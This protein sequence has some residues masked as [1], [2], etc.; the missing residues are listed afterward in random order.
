MR[1]HLEGRPLV[2]LCLLIS[3]DVRAEDWPTYRRDDRRSA[4][5]TQELDAPKLEPA[6]TRRVSLPP[7]PAWHGP[8]QRDAYHDKTDLTPMRDY[9]LVA[10]PIVVG[11]R[12]YYGSTS[13]DAV[14]CL[15]TRSGRELWRYTT[16]GPIRIA[17]T[18]SDGKLYFGSDDGHAYCI[19][20]D[21][22]ALLWS[23]SPTAGR[24]LVINNGRLI[25]F[26]P[27]RGGVI[28]DPS[29]G[30]GGTAYFSASLLPWK[31]SF[32]CAVSAASG[33]PLGDGRWVRRFAA[34]EQRT[35]EGAMAASGDHLLVPQGRSWLLDFDRRTGEQRKKVQLSG[36]GCFVM[37]GEDGTVAGGGASRGANVGVANVRTTAK[38]ISHGGAR[39][40]SIRGNVA[41]LI[42][43]EAL[44]AHDRVAKKRL[45]RAAASSCFAHIVTANA[46]F[47]GGRDVV[48]AH[49]TSDGKLLWSFAVQGDAHGLAA[50]DGALFVSTHDGV[51]QCFRPTA[52]VDFKPALGSKEPG[53]PAKEKK[54][55]EIE[56]I[57]L[58]SSPWVRFTTPDSAAVGWSTEQPSPTSLELRES[59]ETGPATRI[60]KQAPAT[61]HEVTLTGLRR[62]RKYSYSI[63]AL[64]DGEPRLAGPF[65]ID[66]FFN[67]RPPAV[68]GASDGTRPSTPPGSSGL[69]AELVTDVL[70]I[71]RGI[72]LLH[73]GSRGRLALELVRAGDLQVICVD[74]DPD[75]VRATRNLLA[76]AGVY[77]VRAC[78]LHVET[79]DDMPLPDGLANLVVS[80]RLLTRGG[81]SGS[82]TEI[83]RVLR[84]GSPV[85]LG[86][87]RREP[88]GRSVEPPRR[89]L[90]S[91]GLVVEVASTRGGRWIVARRER[92][93]GA[94]SWTHQYG[95][96]ANQAYAGETLGG[97]R[98]RENL[99]VQWIGRP[100]PRY[101]ADRM[102]RKPAPLAT[103][104]R[105][106]LQ[107][108]DRLIALD[109]HNGVPLWS[110]EI[111]GLRR[112]NLP[113]DCANYCADDSSVYVALR[114]ECWRID[115]ATG[116][117][118]A[119]FPVV[120][121]PRAD[122]P[123]DWSFIASDGDLLVGSAT[124]RGSAY[125]GFQGKGAWYDKNGFEKVTSDSLFAVEKDSAGTRWSWDRGVIINSSV[126]L[127]EGAVF[128]LESRHPRVREHGSG[129][130]GLAELWQQ[131]FLVALDSSSG[132]PLWERELP[133]TPGHVMVSLAHGRGRVVLVASQSG[134]FRVSTFDAKSGEPRWSSSV[135][136][137][138]PD[139]GGH[140]SRP[141]IVDRRMYIA[142]AWFDL[143]TGE[144]E[145]RLVYA[146]CG[147]YS[148]SKNTI[149]C[150]SGH[151]GQM[152]MT[153]MDSF[154]G[155][156][157]GRLRPGCWLSTIPSNGMVLV[158]EGGG[159]CWCSIWMETSLAFAPQT[160]PMPT[161]RSPIRRFLRSTLLEL[162][163]PGDG[164]A[165]RF[166]LDGTR[167]TAESALYE[168]PIRIDR[169]VTVKARL[170]RADRRRSRVTEL[171]YSR[172][173]KNL[174]AAAVATSPTPTL[175][176][177]D[178]LPG[179]VTDEQVVPARS[180]T[181]ENGTS[182]AIDGSKV[183][184]HRAE[185]TLRWDEP[186]E[187]SEIIYFG[188]TA[189]LINECFK[190]FEIRLD[191]ESEPAAAGA[192]RQMH[193]PQRVSIPKRTVRQITF[194]FLSSHG[195]P[196][197]GTAEI[198]VFEE[199]VPDAELARLLDWE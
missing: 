130:L 62:G 30:Q 146:K 17:P 5:T 140:M 185:L 81:L 152:S 117:R 111:P 40:M 74:D 186:V 115:A 154:E 53:R 56:K 145:D 132:K 38:I 127:A 125:T 51:I 3:C 177:G 35:F 184:D 162:T 194:R 153:D 82:G 27:V 48:R 193:G 9:D 196:N 50:A 183:N 191:D 178:Y 94:G 19:S 175:P 136:W 91:L 129:I 20:A 119:V 85:V 58:V 137:V 33:K 190:D 172:A 155:S 72:A 46:V 70:R 45:W 124:R 198:L 4:V 160:V 49:D 133:S 60:E 179:F 150:R 148:A 52:T 108:L 23:F 141:V 135:N 170:F 128:L 197:P 149:F 11:N 161:A 122:G 13:D 42:S 66:T 168:G 64:V 167:P 151:S 157:W 86:P 173:G 15:D 95:T 71:D 138:R 96:A 166:T 139:Y 99:E 76:E 98:R 144:R 78:A 67:Y 87:L 102:V 106:F 12:L 39:A 121:S 69:I 84:P 34:R 182:W 126:T 44:H 61:R 88:D 57:E 16:D 118:S 181:R 174:A 159:G 113:R 89:S 31:E 26:W 163:S 68:D 158:P 97:V 169:P 123:Q 112:F 110:L 79:L 55:P 24:R 36:A 47:V 164:G 18:W 2:V 22:G 192:F 54:V 92:Q 101:L 180:G 77:G 21:R 107:G 1:R 65:S 8:A 156:G 73:G 142:P 100:G 116:K 165:I 90:E 199:P 59:G 103:N 188:R 10:Y 25:S 171:T 32:L 7:Q 147:T 28:V 83:A 143:D 37:A 29:A 109:S 176:G 105:L 75:S 93:A 14:H 120:A 6:W 114:G 131:L 104:G 134:K 187:V 195:G 80:D 63:R 189:W 41:Y 43:P